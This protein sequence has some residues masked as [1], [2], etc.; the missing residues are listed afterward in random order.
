MPRHPAHPRRRA[1]RPLSLLFPLVLVGTLA[2]CTPPDGG[3]SAESAATP[4]PGETVTLDPG[5]GTAVE[6]EEGATEGSSGLEGVPDGVEVARGLPVGAA[7]APV[8]AIAG[9]AWSS[10]GA[11]LYV[12][13]VGSSSCP[14]V[15]T[16]LEAEGEVLHVTLTQVGGAVCTMDMAPTTTT[17]PA[18]V[19]FDTAKDATAQLGDLGEVTVP[20]AADPAAVGWLL[21][22]AG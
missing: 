2:A 18:P 7:D 22:P 11:D 5:S 13:T 1:L 3:R 4:S 16:A 14:T 19:G 12:T 17:L 10:S 21:A 15:A 6:P 8:E 9:A 20:A